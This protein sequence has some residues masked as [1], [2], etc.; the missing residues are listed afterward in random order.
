MSPHD[1]QECVRSLRGF[2]EI[3]VKEGLFIVPS[4]RQQP[5]ALARTRDMAVSY[6]QPTWRSSRAGEWGGEEP[7][8]AKSKRSHSPTVRPRR[9]SRNRMILTPADL[10]RRNPAASK[11]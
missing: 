10:R 7:A 1:Q 8:G 6:P 9:R 4:L 2:A 5:K 11:S 3:E